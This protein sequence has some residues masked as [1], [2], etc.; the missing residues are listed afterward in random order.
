M[1]IQ[2]F[3]KV[4]VVF[5]YSVC[6]IDKQRHNFS[7]VSVWTLQQAPIKEPHL[8]FILF[9]IKQQKTKGHLHVTSIYN[10]YSAQSTYS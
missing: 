3:M 2:T 1:C 5:S 8:L 10:S 6:T 7:C 9:I 4:E